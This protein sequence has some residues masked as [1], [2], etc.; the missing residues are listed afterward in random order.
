MGRSK[1]PRP[2]YLGRKLKAIRDHLG[3]TQAGMCK[4]LDFP[5]IRPEHISEYEH[6]K[7]EPPYPIALRYARLVGVPLETL[8][9]DKLKLPDL[10][11]A[12]LPEKATAEVKTDWGANRTLA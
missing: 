10:I 1:R 11:I 4:R 9:D 7:R 5:T 3:L 2:K 8:V 12:R 6:G